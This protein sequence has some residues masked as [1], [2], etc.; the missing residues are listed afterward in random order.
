MAKKQLCFYNIQGAEGEEGIHPN[1]FSV[2]GTGKNGRLRVR[3]ITAAFP[4]SPMTDGEYHF[5]FRC[6]AP[7]GDAKKKG[8][9]FWADLPDP[10]AMVPLFGGHVF[11]KVLRLDTVS[12]DFDDDEFAEDEDEE[13]AVTSVGN[14]WRRNKAE[15]FYDDDDDRFDDNEGVSGRQAAS[16]SSGGDDDDDMM[17]AQVDNSRSGSNQG[18]D[19]F[20]ESP[21]ASSTPRKTPKTKK[22]KKKKRS[23]RRKSRQQIDLEEEMPPEAEEATGNLLGGMSPE[24]KPAQPAS[25][26]SMNDDLAGLTLDVGSQVQEAQQADAAAAAA[27]ELEAEHKHEA[28]SQI[29][30]DLDSWAKD[31][32]G[33]YKQIR[34]LLGTLH[35]VLWQ[36][37]KWKEVG[38][39]D[40]IT[41]RGVKKAYFKAI[42]VVHPDR[43]PNNATPE[44]KVIAE[45]CFESINAAWQIHQGKG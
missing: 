37:S 19:G 29:G 15:Q 28:E 10:K 6:A 24:L 26:S 3:D 38:M 39:S 25:L 45:R 41:D 33:K 32:G 31:S 9:Y 7:G 1:A 8:A 22:K 4:L 18:L 44:M 11:M 14:G 5:R 27:A 2:A 12:H 36:G 16:S 43:L 13:D 35:K 17:A 40:L 20:F 21:P 23:P 34:V 42:R 30:G